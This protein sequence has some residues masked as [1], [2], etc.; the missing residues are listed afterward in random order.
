MI[1]W[2]GWKKIRKIYQK[3]HGIKGQPTY[4]GISLFKMNL[5]IHC[6]LR[7]VYADKGYQVF[8]QRVLLS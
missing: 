8:S 7:E 5:L 3:N 1:H 2:K 4:S 6:N